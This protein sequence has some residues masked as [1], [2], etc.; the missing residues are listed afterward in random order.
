MEKAKLP[1]AFVPRGTF[2]L[3]GVS[4][5]ELMEEYIGRK[6]FACSTWNIG[7]EVSEALAERKLTK[8]RRFVF[9]CVHKR[10]LC[11]HRAWLPLL[12][13]QY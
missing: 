2:Y 4:L 12:F 1:Q 8:V 11:P 7:E 5:W 13:R 9:L 6:L 3:S 10:C